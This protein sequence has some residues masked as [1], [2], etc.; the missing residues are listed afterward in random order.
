MAINGNSIQRSRAVD[1][2]RR[3]LGTGHWA[4]VGAEASGNLLRS[5]G[6]QYLVSAVGAQGIKGPNAVLT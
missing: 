3:G 6:A 5:P 1:G 2:W 4:R